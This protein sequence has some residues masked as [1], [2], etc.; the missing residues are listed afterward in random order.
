M[1]SKWSWERLFTAFN[2]SSLFESVFTLVLRN[3]YDNHSNLFRLLSYNQCISHA[4]YVSSSHWL[5]NY[6]SY[7]F[8]GHTKMESFQNKLIQSTNILVS[9]F[10]ELHLQF[11]ESDSESSR[12]FSRHFDARLNYTSN[13]WEC[14][15]FC[16]TNKAVLSEFPPHLH[17]TIRSM[18]VKCFAKEFDKWYLYQRSHAFLRYT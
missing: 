4:I 8:R 12:P 3:P 17:N 14:A 16:K 11:D 9:F 1:C 7:L 2:M 18:P 5:I 15:S 10:G 6:L 13:N